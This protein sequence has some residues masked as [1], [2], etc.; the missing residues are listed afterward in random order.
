ME[1]TQ[2]QR[3]FASR[4]VLTGFRAALDADLYLPQP[5]FLAVLILSVNKYIVGGGLFG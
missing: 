1:D 3:K 4:T 2:N 5:K